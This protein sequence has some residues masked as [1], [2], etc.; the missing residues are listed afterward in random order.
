MLVTGADSLEL[1]AVYIRMLGLDFH[2]TSPPELV[3]RREPATGS[4]VL[5]GVVYLAE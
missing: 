3:Q 5:L 2:V 4:S 1:I